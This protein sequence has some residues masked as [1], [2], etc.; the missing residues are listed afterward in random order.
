MTTKNPAIPLCVDLDGTLAKTDLLWEA[1]LPVLKSQPVAMFGA[2]LALPRGG[3]ALFKQ[4]IAAAELPEMQGLPWNE[5]LLKALL[6]ERTAGRRLVLCTASDRRYADA[7]ANHLQIF[8]EV[9]ASDGHVNL[10][11]QSK[12]DKLVQI[13]G[14]DGFDYVGNSSADLPV[15]RQA[16]QAWVVAAPDR[17]ERAA[18]ANGNVVRVIAGNHSRMRALLTALRP[19]QWLKNLLIF[20]PIIAAHQFGKSQL[21]Q[22]VI[23]FVAFCLTASATYVLNDL[24][25]LAADRLHPRKRL[26]PFASGAVPVHWGML[27][28]LPLLGMASVLAALLP[29]DFSGVLAGYF[30]ATVVYSFW[31]KR[32]VLIDVLLLAGLY[33]LRIIAGGAAATIPVSFWLLAFSVSIFLSLA[34]A[35]RY[36]EL[37]LVQKSES[38]ARGRG[39]QVGDLSLV[40]SQG[41]ATGLLS[42]LVLALYLNS[43]AAS[44][45]YSH[46]FWLGGVCVLL[47]WWIMRVWFMAH[48]GEMEDDPLLFAVRDRASRMMAIV[49]MLLFWLAR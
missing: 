36:G 13:Y 46:P 5:V 14:R 24:L 25:D 34:L 48:R 29:S 41:I 37:L 15:W 21:I 7:V 26:R 3:R 12:A 44:M 31:L 20:V 33:T 8:D 28:L 2:L 45:L 42:V 11:S 49:A 4:R 18:R 23:A 32:Q 40:Q 1:L 47:L 39:Y 27:A 43:P 16:R 6:E 9:I 10:S 17:V 38:S 19:H 22:A 35:K 30:A